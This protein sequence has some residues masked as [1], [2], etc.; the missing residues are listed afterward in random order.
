MNGVVSCCDMAKNTMNWAHTTFGLQWTI[1]FQVSFRCYHLLI[2]II[3]S[4]VICSCKI[5]KT[6]TLEATHKY[7]V[8]YKYIL[9][10]CLGHRFT[11]PL[12]ASCAQCVRAVLCAVCSPFDYDS[13]SSSS[14]S[15]NC[16]GVSF[17]VSECMFF[18]FFFSVNQARWSGMPRILVG[19]K[20]NR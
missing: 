15:C 14:Y 6:M 8:C 17:G 16:V 1:I 3:N 19:F 10:P 12:C 13:L 18:G 11:G 2:V 4:F 7:N 5:K 20:N 9:I